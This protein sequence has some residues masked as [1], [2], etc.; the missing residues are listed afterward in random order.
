MAK[1]FTVSTRFAGIDNVTSVVKKI[2]GSVAGMSRGMDRVGRA[3]SR[4]GGILRTAVVGLAVG[5]A[6][7]AISSFGDRAD[8]IADVSKRLGMSAEALQEFQFA[9]KMAD[10]SAEDLTLVMQKMNNNLGQLQH[11]QGALLS[12]L[13]SV[14]PQLAVQLKHAKGSEDAFT[15]LMDAISKE[16]NIQKRA[17]IAQAAF[18]KSGQAVIDMAADLNE[19]RKEARASGAII[20]A[21]DVEA[22]AA[23]HNS[24][25]R[26]K[27]SGMGILNSVLGKLAASVGPILEKF[28]QWVQTNREFIGQKIDTVFRVIGNVFTKLGPSVVRIIDMLLPAI[29]QIIDRALPVFVELLDSLL[30]ILPPLLDL[31]API[32]D[33][34]VALAPAL[35]AVAELIRAVLVPVL[36]ILKPVLEMISILIRPIVELVTFL[37]K[38][39]AGITSGPL[40]RLADYMNPGGGGG[41][42]PGY[43][44]AGGS[45]MSPFAGFAAGPRAYNSS[46]DVNFRNVPRGTSLRQVNEVPGVTLNLGRAMTGTPM[47]MLDSIGGR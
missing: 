38:G 44:F 5:A 21:A 46:V 39:L 43:A 17:T 10:L 25:L 9:A 42:N 34:F 41:M 18:G 40:K 2:N 36:M 4:V 45:P 7:K 23:L 1:Q 37:T 29:E 33:I 27:A 22:G 11:G 20:S 13:K 47:Q 16:T 6:G 31:L 15:I 24:L 28:N 8:D 3:A 14:N 35:K 26:I 30:P 19:K 12:T 32:L